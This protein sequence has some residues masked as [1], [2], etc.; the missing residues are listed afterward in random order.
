[1]KLSFTQKPSGKCKSENGNLIIEARKENWE[2]NKYTSARL[3]TKGKFSFQ[4]G[5]VEVRANFLKVAEHGL[6]SG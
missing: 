2:K 1:M 3:L 6:P 4:Y 5:T